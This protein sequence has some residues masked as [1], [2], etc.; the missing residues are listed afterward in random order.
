[1]DEATA[2]AEIRLFRAME[3]LLSVYARRFEREDARRR[4]ELMNTAGP[5]DL[6]RFDVRWPEASK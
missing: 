3:F 5:G 6:G 1:M 2:E 4:V